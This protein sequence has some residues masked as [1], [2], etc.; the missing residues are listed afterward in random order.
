MAR[1]LGKNAKVEV[2][3]GLTTYSM[4]ALTSVTSP[5]A[6][7][8]KKFLSSAERFSALEAY[9]PIVRLDGIISGCELSSL[10][11]SNNAVEISSGSYYLQGSKVTISANT[12]ESLARPTVSGNVI[13]TA[14]SV[15][16]S[17]NITKTA[18][19]E[20]TTSTTRGGAGGPP[21]VPVDEVLLGYITLGYKST[22]AGAVVASNEI[23]NASKERTSIPSYKVIYHD[24]DNL[25][26]I[27]EFDAA[28][29]T[30]HASDVTRNVYAQYWAPADF[31]SVGDAKDISIDES[32]TVQSSQAYGDDYARSAIGTLAWSGSFDFYFDKVDDSIIDL[33][34]NSKRWLKFYPDGDNTEHLTGR[35]I[36][37]A[38][39]SMPVDDTM[40]GSVTLTGDGSLLSK[41]E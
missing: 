7:V 13:V 11:T 34:K 39:H 29:D 26:G 23:D 9:E 20:G 33:I 40:N 14:V 10:T 6:D 41:A 30:I 1:K 8:N 28:L 19:S 17:G 37:A 4:S 22:S 24:S 15:D 25:Y 16:S 2:E 3:L 36:I 5:S 12:A 31:V 38:S 35:A 32:P 21:Y 18:G 27:I